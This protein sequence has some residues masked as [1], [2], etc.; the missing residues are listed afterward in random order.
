[1]D[2]RCAPGRLCPVLLRGYKMGQYLGKYMS[3]IEVEERLHVAQRWTA[4]AF[5]G[6]ACLY[7]SGEKCDDEAN[8]YPAVGVGVQYILKP[9]EGIVVNLEYAQ[10]KAGNYAV[11][12]KLGYGF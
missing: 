3:S 10:G 9:K 6:V 4:T 7:G 12:L 1:M 5:A 11:L 2:G 8:L